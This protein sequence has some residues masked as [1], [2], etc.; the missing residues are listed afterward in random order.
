MDRVATHVSCSPGR[1]FMV[2]QCLLDP[3]STL[4][5]GVEG[6]QFRSFWSFS[7]SI[8]SLFLFH[9]FCLSDGFYDF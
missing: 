6:L 9:S 1:V 8:C 5:Y 2:P 3:K 4:A 7:S